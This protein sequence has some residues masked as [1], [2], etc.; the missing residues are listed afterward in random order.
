MSYPDDTK[1]AK[2]DSQLTVIKK[3]VYVTEKKSLATKS[4]DQMG[5]LSLC[6]VSCC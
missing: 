5:L 4:K 3:D 2:S 1:T 6:S